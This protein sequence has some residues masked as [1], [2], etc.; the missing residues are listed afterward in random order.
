RDRGSRYPGL[1]LVS[2]RG[3]EQA[4]RR[5]RRDRGYPAVSGQCRLLREES[6]NHCP[7]V[8][9]LFTALHFANLRIFEPVIRE[10]AVRGHTVVV[11]A[12]ERETFGGHA[13]V[14]AL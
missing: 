7:E 14:Q 6:A 3:V 9:V 8:K 5:S 2:P 11:A 13:L 1:H 10:L 4:I 12:D